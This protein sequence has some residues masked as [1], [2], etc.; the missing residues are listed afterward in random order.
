MET[1]EIATD[2]LG[3]E[4]VEDTPFNVNGNVIDL[5]NMDDVPD[6][7]SKVL[8][9]PANGARLRIAEAKVRSLSEGKLKKIDLQWELVEGI[10]VAGEMKYA[11]KRFYQNGNFF[12][13]VF[14]YAD[15]SHYIS[16][17]WTSR[18]YL[19]NLKAL[20]KCL[21]L[22]SIDPDNLDGCL[23]GQEIMGTVAQVACEVK[24]E[25]GSYVKDGTFDNCVRYFKPVE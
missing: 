21:G 9:P 8:L 3:G 14:Y 7:S 2:L 11:G 20:G 23:K 1:V 22:E 13:S 5:T 15:T 24:A 16:D 25:D 10:E 19:A 18:K 6:Q 12:D 17:H 4:V